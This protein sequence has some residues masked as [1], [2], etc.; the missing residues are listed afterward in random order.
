MALASVHRHSTGRGAGVRMLEGST[1][2]VLGPSIPLWASVPSPTQL[3]T[4]LRTSTPVLRDVDESGE[5]GPGAS[6]T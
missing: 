1:F 2:L 3:K 5:I 4:A 6:Q